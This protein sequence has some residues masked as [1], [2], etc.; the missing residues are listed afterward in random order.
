VINLIDTA[1]I[2]HNYLE[3]SD[4][5]W[6][7]DNFNDNDNNEINNY[8]DYDEEGLKR[9]GEAGNKKTVYFIK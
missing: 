2:L 4:N 6:E 9:A 3:L 1:V 7:D 5:I 8:D